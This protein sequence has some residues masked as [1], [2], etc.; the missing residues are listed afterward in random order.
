MMAGAAEDLATAVRGGLARYEERL[1]EPAGAV[2]CHADDLPTL[3]G[4]GLPVDVR[5]GKGV[6]P[7]SFWIGPK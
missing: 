7:G 3:E 2:L 5:H 6:P 4:A 1:N